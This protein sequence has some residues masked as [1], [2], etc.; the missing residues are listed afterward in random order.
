MA[1]ITS[2]ILAIVS[3]PGLFFG[4]R[5][6]SLVVPWLYFFLVLIANTPMNLLCIEIMP[7]TTLQPL[8]SFIIMWGP[9]YA[10]FALINL[11]LPAKSA[12]CLVPSLAYSLSAEVFVA[13]YQDKDLFINPDKYGLRL[14]NFYSTVN[15]SDVTTHLNEL[16]YTTAQR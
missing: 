5:S 11:S 10:R 9:S 16:T 12:L 4:I 13:F 1:F 7:K 6:T 15:P 14:N 2:L 8:V 3:L